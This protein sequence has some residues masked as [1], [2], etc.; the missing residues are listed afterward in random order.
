[1]A[2]A[3]P[4][5]VQADP[6]GDQN[7]LTILFRIILVFPHA[8]ILY[9]MQ[10]AVSVITVV[11][12]FAILITGK[13][14]AGMLAFAVD[15]YHWQTRVGGYMYLLT[16]LYP[17]FRTGA[18]DTYPVRFVSGEQSEGRN[19][20]TV[21]FRVILVIPHM[22]VLYFVLLAAFFVLI[23]AWVAGIIAGRVPEGMHNFLAGTLRWNTRVN[24][25]FQLLTDAY[26]PFSLT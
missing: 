13:Y 25:Y 20:L 21:A 3:Y 16:C 26:P 5:D 2:P 15:V 17:P 6:R 12:W 7:R 24:A 22:I 18:D 4:I 23:A 19:R 8:I 9:L 14:P 11:A 1:M 10:I